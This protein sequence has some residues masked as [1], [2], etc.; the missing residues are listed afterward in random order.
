MYVVGDIDRAAAIIQVVMKEGDTVYR[1]FVRSF[2]HISKI[3]L[4]RLLIIFRPAPIAASDSQ[5]NG[6]AV[7]Y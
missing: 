3:F 5:K 1:S 6:I 4:R 2:V 7:G